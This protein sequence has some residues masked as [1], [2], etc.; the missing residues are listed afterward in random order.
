VTALLRFEAHVAFGALRRIVTHASRR[1][2]WFVT[3]AL[4]AVAIVFD[5]VT[6][7]VASRDLGAWTP[8]P[9]VVVMVVVGI[10]VF[11]ALVGTR[12]PLTYGTRAADTIWWRY[13]GVNTDAGQR[14]TTAILTARATLLIALGA[15]PIGALLALAAPQRA[16][17]ILA[18]AA[19]VIVLA[20]AVVLVS[21]AFAPRTAGVAGTSRFGA[22]TAAMPVGVAAPAPRRPRT[23]IP[24]GLMAARWLVA[25]RRR[26]TLVPYD[27]FAFGIVAGF[28]APRFGG[29]AGGQL[30]ALTIVIGGLAL[31]LDASIRGTTAPAT[32]RSPWWRAAIGTLPRALAAWAFCDAAGTASMVIGIV[33]GLGVALGNPLPALA[34]VP[35]ILLLP[36][37]LRLVV[38]VVDTFYP[39]AADRRGAGAAARLAVVW[40]ATIAIFALSVVAGARGGAYASIATATAALSLIVAV[41]AWCGAARLPAAVE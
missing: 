20:P 4:A 41:A 21:S 28:V 22:T 40:Q 5:V 23:T 15:V 31:L 37:A 13:A 2:L 26:E 3:G 7:D 14:A 10:L 9:L 19:M 38:L 35:A 8:S 30:V 29:I 33:L 36:V 27:R 16:G 32:L 1:A 11:A 18:L 17:A 39:A 34:A 24:R 25:T 12:T 6:S